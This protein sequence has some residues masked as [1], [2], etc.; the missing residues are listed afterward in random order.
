MFY[1]VGIG[2][3]PKHITVEALEAL[4]KCGQV[5]LDNYTSRYAE[6]SIEELENILGKKIILLGR[7]GIEEGFEQVL[8]DS[9]AGDVALLVYGNCLTATT[10]VQL[11]I[12]AKK[13]GVKAAVLPGISLT[14]ILAKTGLDE[15]KFGRTVS[16]VFH[17]KNYEPESFHEQMLENKKLG[18]HTLCLLDIRADED[19]L[20]GIPDALK[21]LEKIEKKNVLHVLSESKLVGLYAAGGKNEKILT[22]DFNVLV[23]YGEGGFPQA[24]IVCGKLN[25]KEEEAVAALND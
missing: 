6:G 18:L 19:R 23:K 14:N 1:L 12:D 9:K 16:I 8:K 20:M 10:H 17:E 22:G 5:F 13:M 24:L 21:V 11:L 7:N 4:K 25:E 3:K 2:L 15:Y